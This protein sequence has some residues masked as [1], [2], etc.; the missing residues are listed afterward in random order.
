MKLK[1]ASVLSMSAVLSLSLLTP[2]AYAASEITSQLQDRPVITIANAETEVG[3]AELIKRLKNLFPGKFDFLSEKDFHINTGHRY[4]EDDEA[5]IRYNLSFHKEMNGKQLYGS[6]EFVGEDLAIQSFHYR[7]IDVTDAIFPAKVT[8][9]E[10]LEIAKDFVKEQYPDIAYQLTTNRDFYYPMPRNLTEPI[11]YRFVFEK[12]KN[13]VPILD[14]SLN[15]TIMGNGELVELYSGQ[16]QLESAKYE[17]KANIL[18]LETVVDKVKSNMDV[19]LQYMLEHDYRNETVNVKLTYG[20]DPMVTNLNAK[21]GKWLVGQEFK[22]NLPEMKIKMITDEPMN[23]TTKPI[24]QKEAKAI[25]E[26]LLK[27]GDENTKLRIEEISEHENKFYGKTIYNVHYMYQSKNHGYGASI[28][29]DKNTG[30]VL[31][32]HDVSRDMMYA[33]Q[34][35]KL[36]TTTEKEKAEEKKNKLAYEKALEIGIETIKKFSPSI[37]HEYSYPLVGELMESHDGNYHLSFP[38]VKNGILVQGDSINIGINSDG[39]ILHYNANS[40]IIKEWPSVEKAVSKGKATQAFLDQLNVKLAYSKIKYDDKDYVL[41]YH[42]EFKNQFEYYNALTGEWEKH[43]YYNNNEP[44]SEVVVSHPTAE[45]ELNYLIQAGIIK[46]EDP[47]TF[48]ADQ[49]ITKGEALEIIMKSIMNYYEFDRFDSKKEGTFENINKDHELYNV[50]ELAAQQ[51]IVDT[52]QKAFPVDEKIT[53]QELA[54]WYIRTLGLDEAAKHYDIYK[55]SFEDAG[56]VTKPYTGYVA[57]ATKLGLFETPDNKFN[58]K[59]NVTLAEIAVANIKLA[60]KVS[61]LRPRY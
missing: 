43:S 21:D 50:I 6:A 28:E 42:R 55:L 39:E 12:L 57:L 2:Q 52:S 45:K 58:A 46:V 4:P 25:A 40:P 47:A 30:E 26:K 17:D 35:S 13:E 14:Q 48:D 16:Y 60:Q 59:S 51:N 18:S 10:A 22:D 61:E 8:E 38:R 9:E 3:K 49:P 33:E 5:I 23:V 31:S 53:K 11:Q 24:T 1:K 29:I 20:V 36:E 15:V 37:I 32:F 19:S 44:G 41:M 27:P 56:D 7:P 54:Y 34:A